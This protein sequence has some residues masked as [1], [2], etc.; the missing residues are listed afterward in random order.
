[1]PDFIDVLAILAF[2]NL[3]FESATPTNNLLIKLLNLPVKMF[4]CKT[5]CKEWLF[6]VLS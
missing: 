6:S 2:F 5:L 1:M 3:A 4:M